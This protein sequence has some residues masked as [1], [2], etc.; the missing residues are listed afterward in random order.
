MI[1]LLMKLITEI[2]KFSSILDQMI[3]SCKG[4]LIIEQ[5][6]TNFS[7]CFNLSITIDAI[8]FIEIAR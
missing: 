4:R 1:L 5:V 6:L 8:F 2:D 3:L 7:T